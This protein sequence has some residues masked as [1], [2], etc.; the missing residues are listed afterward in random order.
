[1]QFLKAL[2]NIAVALTVLP[3]AIVESIRDGY[4]QFYEVSLMA[5]AVSQRFKLQSTVNTINRRRKRMTTDQATQLFDLRNKQRIAF[6]KA[7]ARVLIE[8]EVEPAEAKRRAEEKGQKHAVVRK[9][10]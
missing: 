5:V 7:Y 4:R 6:E 8:R 10:A 2:F 3:R 1:M 9:A